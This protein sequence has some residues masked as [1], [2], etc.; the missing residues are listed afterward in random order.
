MFSIPPQHAGISTSVIC[1]ESSRSPMMPKAVDEQPVE[2]AVVLTQPW[3][4]LDDESIV[5]EP[6]FDGNNEVVHDVEPSS[7]SVRD[8]VNEAGR[9]VEEDPEPI[10]DVVRTREASTIVPEY[11]AYDDAAFGDEQAEGLDVGI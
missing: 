11:M 3:Q 4:L 7:G 9:M 2:C 1:D 5:D 8:V 10:T 6:T